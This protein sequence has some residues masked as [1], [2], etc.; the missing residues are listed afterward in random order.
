MGKFKDKKKKESKK[1]DK[2]KDPINH[3][4]ANMSDVARDI[5]LIKFK[6]SDTLE[7][8]FSKFY[9]IMEK[10]GIRKGI[11]TYNEEGEKVGRICNTYE[12]SMSL[13]LFITV[14]TKFMEM[15]DIINTPENLSS[16]E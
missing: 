1:K 7:D 14:L 6:K 9:S 2:E 8:C 12:W 4:Q 3:C 16:Y 13:N 10:H 5:I 11:P 15:H